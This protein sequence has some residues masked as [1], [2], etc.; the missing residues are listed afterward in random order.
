M[1]IWIHCHD[2][3]MG[4]YELEH[5][6]L[7]EMTPKTP[8]WYNGLPAWTPAGQAPL[9]APLFAQAQSQGE[10]PADTAASTP[11]SAPAAQEQAPMRPPTYLMWSILLTICCCNPVGII[12]I[13]TGAQVNYKYN[14][15][16]YDG[17]RRASHITEW[18]VIIAFVL[19][20]MMLP[21]NLLIYM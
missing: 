2:R 15:M 10:Q 16:D 20:L 3:Q 19:G 21:F 17:A 8:V 9:T 1:K 7:Q 13:I 12:P 4:P 5:L 14:N 11:V 6:P 18:G